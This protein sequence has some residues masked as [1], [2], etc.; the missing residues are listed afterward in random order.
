M[1]SGEGAMILFCRIF[2]GA[3]FGNFSS[4]F[5][6]AAGGACA[7]GL[8]ILVKPLLKKEQ[9]W[10]AGVLG[11]IAHSLGQMAMALIMTGT[12]GILVYLPALV[13]ISVITGS[14]TGLCAQFLVNRGNLSWKISSN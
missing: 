10:V 3:V 13:G 12:P 1:G 6:S 14:F 11:A 4:I 7:I 5:Y 8:T 9:L 2:L